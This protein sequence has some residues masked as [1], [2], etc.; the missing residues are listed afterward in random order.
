MLNNVTINTIL[1]KEQLDESQVHDANDQ[2]MTLMKSTFISFYIKCNEMIYPFFLHS[3]QNKKRLLKYPFIRLLQ[4]LLLLLTSMPLCNIWCSRKCL[5]DPV[6]MV[7]NH[8]TSV[9]YGFLI[10]LTVRSYYFCCAEQML[11]WKSALL[12][13]HVWYFCR[14]SYEVNIV[15]RLY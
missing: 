11:L 3:Y 5:M 2:E 1:R 15:L 10:V 4:K 7:P 9:E 14:I 8:H 6:K 13:S 12:K